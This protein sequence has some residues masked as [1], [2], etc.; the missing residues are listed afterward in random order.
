M[1]KRQWLLVLLPLAL[2]SCAGENRPAPGRAEPTPAVAKDPNRIALAADSPQRRLI[3]VEAA[4]TAEIPLDLIVAPGKIEIN[5]NRTSRVVLPL[6]G[7]IAAVNVLLGDAVEQGESLL[8]VDSTEAYSALAGYR[9]ARSEIRQ[10]EAAVKKVSSD[11]DRLTALHEHRAVAL[12]EVLDANH[13]LTDTKA[14]LEQAKVHFDEAGRRLEILG[15]KPDQARQQVVVRAPVSGK[16]LDIDVMHGEYRNDTSA[17][18]MTIADLSSVWVSSNV[19]ESAIRHIRTGELIEIHLTAYPANVFHARVT[20]IADTVD[21]ESRTVKVQAELKNPGGRLR[22][23][24]FGEIRH[25]HGMKELPVVPASAVIQGGSDSFV[26]VE[27]T[28]GEYER[29]AIETGMH[30]NGLVPVLSGIQPGDP[31]VVNGSI[32]LQSR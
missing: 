16:V 4:T 10:L 23:E 6:P 30:E 29:I 26:F 3:R 9:E 17:P 2:L 22:P 13:Q 21:P 19:P 7:R 15:L 20:R 14:E 18:L 5:P 25:S 11:V 32:L 1:R 28:P 27:R 12:K 31:V 8:T 24:M